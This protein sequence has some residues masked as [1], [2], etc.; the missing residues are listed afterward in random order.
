VDPVFIGD[1][2]VLAGQ[3]TCD[4]QVAGSSLG[5]APLR[6]GLSKLLTPVCLCH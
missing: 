5:W 4:S 3:R 2:V 1:N 6:S